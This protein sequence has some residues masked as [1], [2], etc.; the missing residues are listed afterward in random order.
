[1]C[2]LVDARGCLCACEPHKPGVVD[3]SVNASVCV[4][5]LV[6]SCTLEKKSGGGCVLERAQLMQRDHSFQTR[7]VCAY[8]LQSSSRERISSTRALVQRAS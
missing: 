3:E 2:R 5:E 7:L 6:E 8:T 1:M 4:C